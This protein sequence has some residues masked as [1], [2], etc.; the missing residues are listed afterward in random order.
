MILSLRAR[1]AAISTVVFGVVL[2]AFS[3]GSYQLLD[4]WLDADVTER[5]TQLTDGLHGYLQLGGDTASVAFDASDNDQAAF[6]H[7]ATR[8]FRVYDVE[9]GRRLATSSGFTSLGLELTPAEVRAFRAQP[10]RFDVETAYGR[11]RVA[12]SLRTL[13]GH[14]AYLLQVGVPLAPM[15]AALGRYRDLLLWPVPAALL[16]AAFGAWWL[17]GVALRPLSR[18]AGAARQIDVT[19]LDYRLPVRGADDE[20]DRVAYAFNETLGR[21]EH[22]VGEMRQFSAALAHELRTPLAALRGEIELAL[23]IPG[24]SDAQQ[25]VLSSE[26]EEIDRLTRLIDQILTLARAEAGQIRLTF[27]PVDLGDLAASLVE[28]LEPVAQARSISL[29]CEKS[30]IVIVD[31]DTGWLRRLLLNLLGNALKF[32]EEDGR[33]VVRL[34]RQADMARIDV[35]DSGIGLSI[36]DAPHVFERFFRADRARSPAT[37]GAGLGL[38]LVRWIAE[39]H[40]GTASVESRLGEGS[41]FTVTLPV[42][43]A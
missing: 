25:R 37:E 28:Q 22:A 3:I 33:V 11:L 27:A 41:T 34:S 26:I 15:D 40:R 17:S 5:L 42:G 1:L 23:R 35:E 39:Q 21:L 13:P 20:L 31:G 32:T 2:A 38:S 4:R 9:T 24:T 30:G 10:T 16:A 36:E 14:A 29:S 19:T 7:E 18:M 12:S 43:R 6:V 8:Y